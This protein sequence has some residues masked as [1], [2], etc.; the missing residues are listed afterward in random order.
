MQSA[1]REVRMFAVRLLWQKHRPRDLPAG[2]KPRGKGSAPLEDAGRF[3]DAE[4]LR[5]F[6]RYVMF[7]IPQGRSGEPKDDAIAKRRVPGSVA[8]RNVVEVVRDLG[9][10]DAAFA[11]L[12]MPVLTELTGSI[13]KGEWQACLAAVMRLRSAHPG[14][15]ITGGAG[16]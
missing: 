15:A 11:A 1:D 4:A 9:V 14:L 13:A 10:E 2:W 16:A 3:T 8:K 12:A 5:G 7:G 6:L